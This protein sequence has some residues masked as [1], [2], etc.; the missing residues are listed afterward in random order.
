MENVYQGDVPSIDMKLEMLYTSG[1]PEV[2]PA[3][4]QVLDLNY[5]TFQVCKNYLHL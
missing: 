1:I 3:N 5:Y 2:H 4:S